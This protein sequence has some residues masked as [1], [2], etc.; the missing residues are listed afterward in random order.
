[1]NNGRQEVYCSHA[2][3]THGENTF[4]CMRCR[5]L[6]YKWQD[7]KEPQTI[8]GYTESRIPVFRTNPDF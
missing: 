4:R 1:M 2:W 8:I 3:D 7:P 6:W 5:T